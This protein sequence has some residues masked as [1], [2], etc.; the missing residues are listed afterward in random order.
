M[1]L[2]L[3]IRR[4]GTQISKFK[5]SLFY[6]VQPCLKKTKTKIYFYLYVCVPEYMSVYH[7]QAGA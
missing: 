4:S 1:P 7:M 3:A 6:R 5:A 2:F